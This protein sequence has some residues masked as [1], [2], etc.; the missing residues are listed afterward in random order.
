MPGAPTSLSPII[1]EIVMDVFCGSGTT[2]I[3]AHKAGRIGVGIEI[4]P[5]YVDVAVRRITAATGLTP[6]LDG[7]GRTFDEIAAARLNERED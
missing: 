3:A 7:D 4:D 2:I 6:I 1:G 5:L